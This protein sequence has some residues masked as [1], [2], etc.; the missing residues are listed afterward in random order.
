MTPLQW[1]AAAAVVEQW[2][3]EQPSEKVLGRETRAGRVLARAFQGAVRGGELDRCPHSAEDAP[4]VTVWVAAFPYLLACTGCAEAHVR[5]QGAF[6]EVVRAGS[7][8]RARVGAP[9][10][11]CGARWLPRSAVLVPVGHVAVLGQVCGPCRG[12]RDVG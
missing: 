1:E 9:C 3:G 10:D 7:S 5:V 6:R 12:G 8:A 2:V 4:G 11:A